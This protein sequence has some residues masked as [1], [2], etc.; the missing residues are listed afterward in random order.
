MPAHGEPVFLAEAIQSVL[1]QTYR[2]L[3]LLIVDDS[4]G[5]EIE[6]AI[7]PFLGDDRVDYRREESPISAVRA[8]TK[9]IQSGSAPYFAFLHD[10]DRWDVD[11]LA[12][13]ADFL[14]R[15][16]ECG[17]VISGHIDIDERGRE[18]ARFSAPYPEGIV[19]REQIVPEMQRRNVVD[20]MHCAMVRRATLEMAGP[21]LDDGFPRVFDWELWLRVVLNGPVGCVDAED[22]QYRAHDL[23]MSFRPGRAADFRRMFEHADALVASREPALRLGKDERRARLAS[24]E[25]SEALDRAQE[26]DSKEARQALR[27]ALRANRSVTL[28]DRRFVLAVFASIGGSPM[29]KAMAKLRAARWR[30][31]QARRAGMR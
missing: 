20:V 22:A 13:R 11:F 3:R 15:H 12:R 4:E 16:P 1:S 9:L 10:D 2:E 5:D 7:A 29:R 28:R 6:H 19:P 27:R 31:L 30:R 21:W 25:L 14:E 26:G 17:L 24:I 18:T 8:M 23:Q